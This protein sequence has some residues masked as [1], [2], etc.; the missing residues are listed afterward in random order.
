[1]VVARN[2]YLSLTYSAYPAVIGYKYLVE[3]IGYCG[4]PVAVINVNSRKVTVLNGANYLAYFL[5]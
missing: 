3:Y 4:L 1:M 2:S 5:V